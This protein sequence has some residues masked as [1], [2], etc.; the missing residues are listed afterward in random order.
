MVESLLCNSGDSG[1]IPG[2]GTRIPHT[3]GQLSPWAAATEAHVRKL[4]SLFGK[5]PS[6]T[7][8][9]YVTQC[10]QINFVFF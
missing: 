10:S 4:E 5:D 3:T 2:Q 7:T 6:D 9:I 1:S 8:K